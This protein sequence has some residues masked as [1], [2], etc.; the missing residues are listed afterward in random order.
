MK[1]TLLEVIAGR[2]AAR[3]NCIASGNAEMRDKHTQY[4]HD[5]VNEGMPSGNGFDNGTRIQLNQCRVD[6]SHPD[7]LVFTTEYHH[8]NE[9]GMYDGWSNH[10]IYVKPCFLSSGFVLTITGSNRGGVKDYI[11]EV[12]RNTLRTYVEE[13]V[14]GIRIGG[15]LAD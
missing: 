13:T 10:T 9:H 3:N 6:M 14:D 11:E 2:I 7:R 1:K 5:A 12:F 8:M 4:I 15:G